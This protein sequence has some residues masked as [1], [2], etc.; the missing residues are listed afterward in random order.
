M[1]FK[2]IHIINGDFS[3][4][5]N[6][7]I[8]RPIGQLCKCIW[9]YFSHTSSYIF[10]ICSGTRDL[11]DLLEDIEGMSSVICKLIDKGEEW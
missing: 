8:L 11:K 6:G 1:V 4:C 5:C 3:F 7:N 2:V 10:L 9:V